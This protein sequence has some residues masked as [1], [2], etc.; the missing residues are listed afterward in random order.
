MPGPARMYKTTI[1]LLILIVASASY[2]LNQFPFSV[3]IAVAACA[4]VDALVNALHHKRRFA[5]PYTAIIT[6]MI[7]G[8]VAPSNAPIAVLAAASAIAVLSKHFI[9]ARNGNIF[10][11]A[12]LGLLIALLVFGVGDAWW[13]ASPMPVYGVLLSLTPILVICAYESRRLAAGL[14]FA[15]T[16][17][18]VPL[19]LHGFSGT[20]SAS[21]L[22]TAVI[23]VNYFLAFVMI[24]EPKTSP[25]KR[26]AQIVYGVGIAAMVSL[27][28]FYRVP[29]SLLLPLLIGNIAYAAYRLRSGSR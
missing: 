7:I 15:L 3:V 29:Y 5:V 4:L 11:P 21:G 17:L 18:L 9:K 8:A 20:A 14:S 2:Y 25:H 13:V 6:G 12:A 22:W 24:A 19:A 26:D 16:S 10:N 28:G 27:L 1:L 23:S